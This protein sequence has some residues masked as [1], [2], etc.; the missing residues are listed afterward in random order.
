MTCTLP[1]AIGLILWW[2][3]GRISRREALTLLPF[4][5]VGAAL[6]LNTAWLET[7]HVGAA[8][9]AWDFSIV[10]RILIAGRVPW[11]YLSKLVWPDPLIFIYPRWTVDSAVAWQY[12]FPIATLSAL[13]A[14]WLLRGRIGR[15]PLAAA[16]FFVVTLAPALG[17]FNYYPMRFSFVA[18]HFQYLAGIGLIVLAVAA[19]ARWRA[20]IRSMGRRRVRRRRG[21]GIQS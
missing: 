7:T 8:G 4:L 9:A 19:L 20:R 3:R 16:G 2:K 13:A 11:F 15:G 17:F 21:R 10:Q 18:D 14:L 5:A 6:A 1:V 12:L